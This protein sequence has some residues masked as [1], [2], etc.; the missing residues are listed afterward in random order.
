MTLIYES[1]L[2]ILKTYLRTENKVVCS[3][4]KATAT[5]TREE[6]TYH[7]CVT[8][9]Q[10]SD[11]FMRHPVAYFTYLERRSMP[12]N[13][14]LVTTSVPVLPSSGRMSK[15]SV[16]KSFQGPQLRLVSLSADID[17][18]ALAACQHAVVWNRHVD[19]LTM[20]RLWAIGNFR[21][22]QW[23]LKAG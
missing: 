8:I 13:E 6:L 18:D 4:V 1:D 21:L 7:L 11:I 22:S 9:T 10:I 12:I 5:H 3:L 2:D 15:Q 16:W 14:E 17:D 20:C 23:T 19:R